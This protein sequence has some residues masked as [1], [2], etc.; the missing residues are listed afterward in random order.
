[1]LVA[2][3]ITVSTMSTGWHYAVDV[4]SEILLAVL[5]T[6]IASAVLRLADRSISVKL[7]GEAAQ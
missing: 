3:L 5:S 4:F 1:M 6:I 2:G 7:L